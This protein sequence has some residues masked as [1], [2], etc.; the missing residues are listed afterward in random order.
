MNKVLIVALSSKYVHTLL[1][2]YYLKENCSFKDISI[3]QSNINIDENTLLAQI[4]NYNADIIAFSC[5]IF[6]IKTVTNLCKILK[7][8]YGKTILLGGPEV[9]F[10]YE[11]HF[12]YADFIMLGEGEIVFDKLINTLVNEKAKKELQTQTASDINTQTASDIN[13]QTANDFTINAPN[14][15]HK[16]MLQVETLPKVLRGE[17]TNLQTIK[18]PYTAEY[19]EAVEGKLAYFEASRGCPYK[20]SYC[21]SAT[22]ELRF[23][24]LSYVFCELEKFKHKNIRVLK[25]IDRTFNAKASFS[26]AILEYVIKN[27]DDF[28]FT[29]H[30]EIAP[31]LI[32]DKMVEILKQSPKGF[33]QFEIGVQTFNE[34]ALEAINRP[35]HR[36]KLLENIAKLTSL[37]NCHIHTDLIAGLPYE[38][39]ES[40]KN[41]FNSLYKLNSNQLQLG[42]LKVLKGSEIKGKLGE[43]FVY[44]ATPPYEIESTPVLSANELAILKALENVF[45]KLYNSQKFENVLKY[46]MLSYLSPFDFYLDFAN[47]TAKSSV[48]TLFDLHQQ[49]VAF[50]SYKNMNTALIKDI[51]R[52]DYSTT[53]NSRRLPPA[54]SVEFDKNFK[55][56]LVLKEIDFKE[57]F[58]INLNFNPITFEP[59]QLILQVDYSKFDK[60]YKAYS[61]K[62]FAFS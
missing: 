5:Y 36:A 16:K 4:L 38:G 46:F 58:C 31:E 15:L 61:Y 2:P 12:A 20:C 30:F 24:D 45:D 56:Q 47:F 48:S 7:A 44:S 10:E 6:N 62:F 35:F 34:Q 52:F 28:P 43:G 19:F 51:L 27:C 53:N 11:A 59:Q 60:V 9:S 26:N 54:I 40:F 22:M 37:G 3:L 32:D 33:I 55:K 49:L 57:K 14:L 17:D 8:Q 39:F 13:A 29:F 23:F 21:M 41:S 1:A 50:A 42:F 25:F 18:T